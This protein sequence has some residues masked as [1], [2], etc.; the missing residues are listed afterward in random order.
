MANGQICRS[1]ADSFLSTIFM[2][3]YIGLA[4]N[5]SVPDADGGNI[6][7]PSEA[8]GYKRLQLKGME[9]PKN[10][11]IHNKEIIFMGE[12]LGSWGTITHFIISKTENG[13]VIFHAPLN[14]PVS[15]PEGNIP[16][17]RRG[18]LIVGID[19]DTLDTPKFDD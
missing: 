18:A 14:I 15:V 19:K 7:E 6:T 9:T 4:T 5:D 12:A 17:F 13:Q 1:Q 3:S 8:A 10:G 2:N 11:Q 16:I